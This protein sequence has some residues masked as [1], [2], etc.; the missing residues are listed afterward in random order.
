MIAHSLHAYYDY[1]H[2]LKCLRIDRFLRVTRTSVVETLSL[3][4]S[5]VD[6]DSLEHHRIL[7]VVDLV[8]RNW[9]DVTREDRAAMRE[10]RRQYE[11][12]QVASDTPVE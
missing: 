2:L 5:V 6:R 3:E 1:G 8:A 7:N 12:S 10:D 4:S 11:L 9:F